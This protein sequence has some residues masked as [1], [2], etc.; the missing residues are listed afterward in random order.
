ML[1]PLRAS[2]PRSLSTNENFPQRKP[3][4]KSNSRR[5]PPPPFRNMR[6]GKVL[7]VRTSFPFLH[8]ADQCC[9]KGGH[10]FKRFCH[11]PPRRRVEEEG[12][13]KRF[14]SGAYFARD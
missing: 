14:G 7:S 9:R 11:L 6:H 1:N 3:N 8:P 5:V 4:P 10:R 12:T 2:P 13:S